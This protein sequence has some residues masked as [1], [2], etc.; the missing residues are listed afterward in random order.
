MKQTKVNLLTEKKVLGFATTTC[1]TT[2]KI[3]MIPLTIPC[4]ET[5][6]VVKNY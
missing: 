4:H 1:A 6:E 2:L 5:S 3:I